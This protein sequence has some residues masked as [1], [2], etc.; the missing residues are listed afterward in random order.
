MEQE[1]KSFIDSK[2]LDGLYRILE[3]KALNKA[4]ENFFTKNPDAF[5][6]DF[7]DYQIYVDV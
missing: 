2:E 5:D 4:T 7:D 3:Q 1:N 6:N